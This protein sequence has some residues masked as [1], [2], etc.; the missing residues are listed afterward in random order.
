MSNFSE[1]IPGPG[2]IEKK[3]YGPYIIYSDAT[4]VNTRWNKPVKRIL[5]NG[6]YYVGLRRENEDR[7]K[8]YSLYRILYRAFVDPSIGAQDYIIPVDGNYENLDISNLKKVSA[9][10]FH[11]AHPSGRKKKITPKEYQEICELRKSGMSYRTI[12]AKYGIS[13]YVIQKLLRNGYYAKGD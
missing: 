13:H 10:E 6:R 5:R 3:V 12:A 4:I 11:K 1:H 8:Y 7:L 9:S 2:E